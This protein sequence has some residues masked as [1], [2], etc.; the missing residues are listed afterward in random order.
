M[1]LSRSLILAFSLLLTLIGF[2]AAGFAF[3]SAQ[4]ETWGLLDLQQHQIARFVG[5]GSSLS[6]SETALPDHE[7]DEDYIVEVVYADGRD[8]RRSSTAI[9]IPDPSPEGFSEFDTGNTRWR[10]LT[11]AGADYVTKVAQQTVVRDELA[12]NAALGAAVPFLVAIPFS[13]WLVYWLVGLVIRRLTEV[14]RQVEDRSPTDTT[15]ISLVRV[16]TEA[17][18]LVEAM[19]GALTRLRSVL[20][21][22]RAF[23]SDA[24]HELRTPLAAVTLQVGNLK[25]HMTDRGVADRVGELERGVRRA[26]MVT[27]QLLRL[28]RQEAEERPAHDDGVAL[29]TLALEVAGALSPVADAKGVDLGFVRVDAVN[30]AGYANDFRVMIECLVDNAIKYTQPGGEIDVSVSFDGETALL[31]ITDTGPGIPDA[32]KDRVFDRF[33]RLIDTGVEGSGLGLA[34]A[35]TVADRY[36]VHLQIS[37]RRDRS[38]LIAIL[39]FPNARTRAR[40]TALIP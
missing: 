28:A 34:I 18:P 5:D 32:L 6:V 2:L 40:L 16:P 29:D 4:V 14:T 20:D 19:N 31:T 37:N 24:A 25:A 1:S 27:D 36:S 30:V 8:I 35:R 7:T 15:P 23:L 39:T 22:Q 33:Y 13:W 11:L 3:W 26:V 17:R 9:A 21:Q 38:G 12:T 10:L